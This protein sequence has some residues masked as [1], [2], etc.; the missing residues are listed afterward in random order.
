M[1][2]DQVQPIS[3]VMLLCLVKY[4]V[5][6]DITDENN[7]PI[8]LGPHHFILVQPLDQTHITSI[9]TEEEETL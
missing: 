8:C 6:W 2:M 9:P 5:G 4:R 3:L 1:E 7:G